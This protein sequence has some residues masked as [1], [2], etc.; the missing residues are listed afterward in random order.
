MAKAPTLAD[1][2]KALP[3]GNTLWDRLTDEESKEISDLIAAHWAL[4]KEK[5]RTTK[6]IHQLISDYVDFEI[7]IST[8][9]V[10]INDRRPNG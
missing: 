1:K 5:R 2:M 9:K 8:V 4:P 6:S 7:G 10:W 3:S